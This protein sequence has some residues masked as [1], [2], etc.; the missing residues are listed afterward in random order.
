MGISSGQQSGVGRS[1]GL[2]RWALGRAA[3]LSALQT[4]TL[5]GELGLVG[6]TQ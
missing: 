4:T 6:V 5:L 3:E 1:T 2:D